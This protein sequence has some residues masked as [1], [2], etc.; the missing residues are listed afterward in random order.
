[1]FIRGREGNR[2]GPRID[3]GSIANSCKGRWLEYWGRLMAV[4][5][6]AGANKDCMQAWHE[7]CE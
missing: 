7:M 3:L 5:G 2:N 6:A 1:M 4:V